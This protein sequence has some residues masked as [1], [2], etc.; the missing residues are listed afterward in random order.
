MKT[1]SSHGEGI[2]SVAY[3]EDD[4]FLSSQAFRQFSLGYQVKTVNV[5]SKYGHAWKRPGR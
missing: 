2:I 4:F 3:G 5:V 1:S